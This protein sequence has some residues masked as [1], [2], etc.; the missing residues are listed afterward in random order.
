MATLAKW[1]WTVVALG[2]LAW[3]LGAEE[4]VDLDAVHRIRDEALQNSKVMD[5]MFYLTDVYG[6]R[7]T[8][9]PGFFGAADWVVKQLVEWGI[10]AHLEKWGPFGRGWTF[11]HFSGHLIEPQYAP[12][13]GFP[14]AFSP[15]TGGPVT[16]EV[17]IAV[18]NA[19]PDFAKYKDKLRGKIVLV[20]TG[21]ELQ[22]SLQPLAVRRSDTDLAALS[23]APEPPQFGVRPPGAVA[24]DLPGGRGGPGA[25]A[26]NQRFQRALNRFLS[27]EGATIVVRSGGARSEGG[28]VF[29]QGA[30]SR[31]PKD[32]VPPPTVVLTPE[33]Y[34]RVARLL[35]HKIPVKLEFDIQARFLDEGNDS[36]NVIGDI[37]GGRKKDEVVMIGAHLDSWQGGTGATDNA[38]GSAVMIE[39]MR[40]LKTLNLRLDR[41]VR[42]ALWSGEEQGILGSRAYVA[43]HFAAREDMKLKPEHAKLSGYFNVDN[44]SGKIRGINLQGNDMMRPVFEAWFKPLQ[45]LGA[46][47]I[48]IRNVG[49]TDHLSFN[50][51]GL[52]GFQFIQDPLEYDSRTHHSNMDVYD[53][54]QR[55]DMMQMAAIVAS[56]VYNAANRE[57]MLP[58]KPLPKP[59]PPQPPAG[60]GTPTGAAGAPGAP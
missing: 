59:Q 6:P 32:P 29:G 44:G 5:H 4:R 43:E 54:V 20:G 39:V 40:I 26:Q 49:G 21:R 42:M 27:D 36:V 38:A 1:T 7:V 35:D 14:L 19:E 12:L 37:E 45:D 30:G 58:R 28:T 23:Q 57:E 25:F 60:G 24:A 15:G 52:P 50:A 9:S 8:N 33:H 31:D 47:T 46:G 56:F 2:A 51:V 18:L 55:G 17:T 13:I 16:G 22:M 3:P 34:N 11:T 41:S 10:K 48:A 53:R